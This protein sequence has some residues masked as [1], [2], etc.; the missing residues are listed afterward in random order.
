MMRTVSSLPAGGLSL[1]LQRLVSGH[2]AGYSIVVAVVK[3]TIAIIPTAAA[4]AQR[5]HIN[6][7]TNVDDY[8][9]RWNEGRVEI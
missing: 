1:C 9:A 7:K 8:C 4:A 5:S 3:V 2:P 6:R